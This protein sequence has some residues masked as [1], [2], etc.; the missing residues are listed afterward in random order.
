[1]TGKVYN[2]REIS[3][4]LKKNGYKLVRYSGDHSIWEHESG[5]HITISIKPNPTIVKRLI[6]EYHL[7]VS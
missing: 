4:I 1:M 5:K 6:K 2:F 7:N 3:R